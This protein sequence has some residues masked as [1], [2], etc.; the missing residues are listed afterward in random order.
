LTL[1]GRYCNSNCSNMEGAYAPSSL[2]TGDVYGV[3]FSPDGRLLASSGGD[4][5]V[6]LWDLTPAN[7]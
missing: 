5:T 2:H 4:N 7:R 1:D 6:Q 3:A